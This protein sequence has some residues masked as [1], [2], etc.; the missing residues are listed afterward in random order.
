[1]TGLREM[2]PSGLAGSHN[3]RSIDVIACCCLLFLAIDPP[4]HL[5]AWLTLHLVPT[6]PLSIT[7][8][9]VTVSLYYC[10]DQVD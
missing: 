4:F 3:A 7:D 6:L 1:M 9:L 5:G 2:E 10:T 8:L